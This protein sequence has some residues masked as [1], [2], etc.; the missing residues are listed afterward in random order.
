MV[1][2]LPVGNLL[3]QVDAAR[4]EAWIE[5]LSVRKDPVFNNYRFVLDELNSIDSASYCTTVAQLVA[6]AAGENIYCRIRA[7]YLRRTAIDNEFY[8]CAFSE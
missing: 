3:G 5:K 6:R 7:G 4:I 1:F 2:L 8:R